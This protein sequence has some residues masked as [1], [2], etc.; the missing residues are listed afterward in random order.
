MLS[1]I[2]SGLRGRAAHAVHSAAST[3]AATI[4]SNQ[5]RTD[6]IGLS[7]RGRIYTVRRFAAGGTDPSRPDTQRCGSPVR[8]TVESGPIDSLTGAR[9]DRQPVRVQ[10]A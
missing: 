9:D 10:P 8:S 1:F 5:T 2:L 4:G 3:V 7:H 6:I